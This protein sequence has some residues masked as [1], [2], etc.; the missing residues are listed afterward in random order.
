MGETIRWWPWGQNRFEKLNSMRERGKKNGK[1]RRWQRR[2]SWLILMYSVDVL[3]LGKRAA[4]EKACDGKKFSNRDLSLLPCS[5]QSYTSYQWMVNFKTDTIFSGLWDYI[6]MYMCTDI[7]WRVYNTQN[8]WVFG[9]CPLS[10]ILE[11]IKTQ[12][13][14]NWICFRP[15][16]RGETPNLLGPLERANLR[17]SDWG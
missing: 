11:T 12:R 8:Y 2:L 4:I 10:G 6:V 13:F 17:S 9:L 16:V 5:T 3:L 1:Q 7:F 15:Q 14:G